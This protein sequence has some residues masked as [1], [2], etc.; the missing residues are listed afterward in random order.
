VEIKWRILP[1]IEVHDQ[2]AALAGGHRR[3]AP[4]ARVS[5]K[6]R[7]RRSL[8]PSLS[9]LIHHEVRV[10]IET[11]VHE[12]L[13]AA[14]RTTPYERSDIRRGYRR[15]CHACAHPVAAA[16]APSRSPDRY[17]PKHLAEKILTSNW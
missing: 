3:N 7:E 15:F 16:G 9:E 13:C 5:G 6:L 1:V 10:A 17:T 14:L 8:S 2:P 12:E 11:A 4:W